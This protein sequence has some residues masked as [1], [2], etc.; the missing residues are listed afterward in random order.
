MMELVSEG[1]VA[2]QQGFLSG[3]EYGQMRGAA[4]V[5]AKM[6]SGLRRN[7]FVEASA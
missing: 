2:K 7:L 1:E 4:S 6:L 3:D 5:V